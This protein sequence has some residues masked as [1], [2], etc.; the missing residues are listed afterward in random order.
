MKSIGSSDPLAKK[1][2]DDTTGLFVSLYLIVLAFFVVMNSISNQDQNKVNAAQESVTR[3]FK[4]L[5]E[6]EADFVDATANIDSET[7]N[8]EFYDQIAGVFASLVGFEGR[9]PTSGGNILRVEF[10]SNDLFEDQSK[11]FRDNQKVFLDQLAV[12]LS[13]G[14]VSEKREME[15]VMSSGKTFPEGPAYWDDTN[16]LRA[17]AFVDRLKKLGVEENKLSIGITKGKK[18]KITLTFINRERIHAIQSLTDYKVRETTI[19]EENNLSDG[20]SK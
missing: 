9:F 8:D 3:A 7:P 16:I 6:P 20:D 5:Y 18:D 14:R 11:E 15:I 19:T 12:F 2:K 13:E 10:N 4:N 17:G 1:N